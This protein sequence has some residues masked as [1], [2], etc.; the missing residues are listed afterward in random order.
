MQER[1]NSS[2]HSEAPP[3]QR[4]TQFDLTH[5]PGGLILWRQDH[6]GR[7]RG[8]RSCGTPSPKGRGAIGGAEE[9]RKQLPSRWGPLPLAELVSLVPVGGHVPQANTKRAW[10][11]LPPALDDVCPRAGGSCPMP[12]TLNPSRSIRV[13]TSETMTLKR[14]NYF[15]SKISRA[16]F[17]RSS[18]GGLRRSAIWRSD[19]GDIGKFSH[20]QFKTRPPTVRG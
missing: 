12:G 10:D 2:R 7:A 8:V 5:L 15:D 19:T 11:G 16:G 20:P 1:A 13:L 6:C 18:P 14:R 3:E 17:L 4:S 9:P